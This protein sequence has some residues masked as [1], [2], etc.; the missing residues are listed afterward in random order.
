MSGTC[1]IGPF[2]QPCGVASAKQLASAA[3]TDLLSQIALA[4]QKQPN[5]ARVLHGDRKIRQ[6][7]RGRRTALFPSNKCRGSVPVESR[8]ELAYAVV[9]EGSPSVQDYRTQAIRIRL[10]SGG[11]AHPDFL[12]RTTCGRVEVHEVK[13]SIEH[14][15][16]SD[17]DRFT[18]TRNVLDQ[19]GVG[20]RLID[21]HSLPSPPILEMLLQRYAR[22][23]MLAF[24]KAQID[25][26]ISLLACDGR[27]TIDAAYRLMTLHDLPAQIVDFLSFHQQ[28]PFN[29]PS[30][31]ALG[32][33]GAR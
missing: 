20:F 9:L 7:G 19:V 12:I 21:R 14:L 22:G 4:F 28:W 33:R 32:A 27:C 3:A 11:F 30:A 31:D 23:H 8:L 25:L 24:S 13:P 17:L 1:N 26:A 5:L 15:P 18:L 2:T 16:Q 29:Q 6:G 10:P